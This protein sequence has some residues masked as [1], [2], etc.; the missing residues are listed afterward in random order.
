MTRGKSAA[1]IKADKPLFNGIETV[2]LFCRLIFWVV[3]LLVENIDKQGNEG[4]DKLEPLEKI[5][6]KFHEV[7][8]LGMPEA[9]KALNLFRLG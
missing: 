6:T 9:I 8:F 7:S 1:S 3:V 2:R 5:F 4:L